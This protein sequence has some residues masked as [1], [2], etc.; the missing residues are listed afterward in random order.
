MASF[1]KVILLGN[2]TRDPEHVSGASS[3]IVN[4]GIAVNDRWKDERGN[5][6][7]DALFVD[8]KAFAR[9]AEV[10]AKYCRKGDPLLIEGRLKRET[11]SDRDTGKER[12]ATRVYVSTM[13]LL[14]RR[15]DGAVERPAT[16]PSDACPP[17]D[18]NDDPPF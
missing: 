15:H 9:T 11:W 12:S 16:R 17:D 2:L 1:N 10:I 14:G 6:H 7:E 18:Q 5:L 13:Q 8:C 4:F 3:T